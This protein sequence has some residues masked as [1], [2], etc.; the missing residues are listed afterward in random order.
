MT[1]ESP[2]NF[3]R[4]E[5]LKARG[6]LTPAQVMEKSALVTQRLLAMEE[7]RRASTI[8]AYMDFRNE[9]QTGELVVAAMGAGKKVAIPCTDI[10]GRRLVPSLIT[11]Y[12]G[13]LQPG[14][15]GIPEPK[16]RSLKPL[17]PAEIDLVIVPG[18]AYDLRGNRL[19][20]G[21]GF[22][23][24]FLQRTK[25]GAIYVAPAF[26]LQLRLDVYPCLHDVPVHFI[27][28]EDRLIK[29]GE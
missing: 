18:V 5:M 10:A 27:V 16:P 23:D 9:A 4:K 19:G 25:P 17:D 13:D 8:M 1:K 2:K 26:E 3:L 21:G 15:W 7:Y 6:A 12:P 14:A 20:Y 24:R 28:T 29:V 22:Y 11:N